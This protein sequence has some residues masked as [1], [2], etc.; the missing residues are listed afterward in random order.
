MSGIGHSFRYVTRTFDAGIDGVLSGYAWN[1]AT[2]TYSF[3]TYDEYGY[4]DEAL[5]FSPVTWSVEQATRFALD[6][7]DGNAANDGFSVEGFT[8]VDV[9][10]TF[11]TDAH[12]RLGY[13]D[14]PSTAWAY[15]PGS[16]S[17]TGDIWLGRDPELQTPTAGNWAWSTVL[18]EIGHALGLKHPHDTETGPGGTFFPMPYSYDAMEYSIMSYS[19]F[20]G[21]TGTGYGNED[22]GFAQTYMMFDIAALQEMYGADYTTN[23]G[24]TTYKWTPGSGTTYVNGVAAITPGA[25]R[26]FATIWDGGGIDTYDLSS[27]SNNLQISL[28]A[29][30]SSLFSASQSAYLGVNHYASGNI[31]NALLYHGNQQSL[32]ENA[33]G[34]SGN[35]WIEGNNIANFLSGSVG[36]DTLMGQSGN[37]TLLGGAGADVLHGGVG[38]DAASY[39]NSASGVMANL[40]NS[41]INTGDA[42]GDIYTG[43]EHLF[44]SSHAD[45]LFGD[46][47]GNFLLGNAGDDLLFGND[48][49]D[50]IFGRDD[51][52]IL[53][54]GR[55]ADVLDGGNG[56]DTASYLSAAS[57]VVVNLTT[58]RGSSGEAAGDSLISIEK[59]VGSRFGDTLVGSLGNDAIYGD[60]G[61]D[62]INASV[63]HD[64][65][66]GG[67]GDD[68]LYGSNGNDVLGGG[69]GNDW[70]RG[71]A[72][73]DAFVFRGVL[74]AATNVDLITDFTVGEDVIRLGHTVMSALGNTFGTLGSAF[75]HASATG[76]A[77]TASQVILYNSTTGAL[78]Y[79]ADGNGAGA[80]IQFATLTAGLALTA[81]DF[82]VV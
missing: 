38:I 65:V 30:A 44:G 32:I 26:I 20:V 78:V 75:F 76:Q 24:N 33:I 60:N 14:D 46:G 8:G 22:Y 48:G 2:I 70:L 11:A 67:N 7:S 1:D 15:F 74:D 72:G 13:S 54:G 12:L 5:T 64:A 23:S 52:D 77:T 19:S 68:T 17:W 28:Q 35:D 47:N 81:T 45:T 50:V 37:D 56:F 21:D 59:L 40:K 71:G 41:S 34:G 43:I 57:G 42:A 82:A 55:G 36:N 29:G 53:V 51:N 18:H 73:N 27:Y 79:D 80:G 31:Y 25:N 61:N 39:G 16:G 3:P 4:G 10:Q 49:N 9:A 62:L 69:A 63:G 6:M 66:W 58:G